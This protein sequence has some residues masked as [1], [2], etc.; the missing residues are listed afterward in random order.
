MNYSIESISK[1]RTTL[2]LL[3]LFV[4]SHIFT[5]LILKLTFFDIADDLENDLDLPKKIL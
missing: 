1:R 3:F 5:F 2:F 4:Q